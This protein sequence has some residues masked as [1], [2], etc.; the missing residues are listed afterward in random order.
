[1]TI[2]NMHKLYNCRFYTLN[3]QQF[4]SLSKM[5]L[6]VCKRYKGNPLSIKIQTVNSIRIQQVHVVCPN[7]ILKYSKSTILEYGVCENPSLQSMCV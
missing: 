1:M 7:I 2:E 5:I 3:F 4:K 6:H